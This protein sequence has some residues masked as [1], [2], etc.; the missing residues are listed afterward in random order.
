MTKRG[1][2]IT[3][4]TGGECSVILFTEKVLGEWSLQVNGGRSMNGPQK[5]RVVTL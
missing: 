3:T 1:A 4:P 5:K 2:D